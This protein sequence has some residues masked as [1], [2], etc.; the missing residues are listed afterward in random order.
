MEKTYNRK[1]SCAALPDTY[2]IWN[3]QWHTHYVKSICRLNYIN[4]FILPH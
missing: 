4:E 1:S 2:Y 3:K